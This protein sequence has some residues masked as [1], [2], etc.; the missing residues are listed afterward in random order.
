MSL[1]GVA[2]ITLFTKR[3]SNISIHELNIKIKSA[4]TVTQCVISWHSS[5]G[6]TLTYRSNKEKH[7]FNW[8]MSRLYVNGQFILFFF[9]A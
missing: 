9:T 5:V 4:T 3:T 6:N 1:F 2:S 7:D 8:K